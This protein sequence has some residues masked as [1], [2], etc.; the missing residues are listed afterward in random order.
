[1][2][3]DSVKKMIFVIIN[4]SIFIFMMVVLITRCFVGLDWVTGKIYGPLPVYFKYF[5]SLSN[6]YNGFVCLYLAILVIKRWKEEGFRFTKMEKII[7]LSACM[8]VTVTFFTTVTFLTFVMDD[9]TYL[10]GG[11]LTVMHVVAPILTVFCYLY[12]IKAEK[13]NKKELLFA[14]IPLF[15]YATVYSI[16]VLTDVWTDHYGFTFGGHKWAFFIAYPLMNGLGYLVCFLLELFNN[17]IHKI[18]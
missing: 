2:S 5:T 18:K 13:I 8:G 12:F 9:M 4:I 6:F 7:A 14:V 11:E 3:K 10:Y 1:M 16:L 15:L 17:L